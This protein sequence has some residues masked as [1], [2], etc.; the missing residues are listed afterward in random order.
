MK[1]EVGKEYRAR[2]GHRARVM[3]DDGTDH[4][5]IMVLHGDYTLWHRRDG[6][7][8]INCTGADLVAEWD[9]LEQP[10]TPGERQTIAERPDTPEQPKLWSDMT[11]DPQEELRIRLRNIVMEIYDVR[12]SDADK[13][14]RAMEQALDGYVLNGP[15]ALAMA[16]AMAEGE[17]HSPDT[18]WSEEVEDEWHPPSADLDVPPTRIMVDEGDLSALREDVERQFRDTICPTCGAQ[19]KLGHRR[20]EQCGKEW[21]MWHDL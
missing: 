15:D 8:H 19:T 9:E 18:N 5:P 11:D 2:D 3:Y 20:C 13:G 1:I 16:M 10:Y 6:T 17:R 4:D 7:P 21:T 12:P 14:I